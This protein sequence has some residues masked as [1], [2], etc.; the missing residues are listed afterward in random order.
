MAGDLRGVKLVDLMQMNTDAVCQVTTRISDPVV[1]ASKFWE[2]DA[3]DL[4]EVSA[5]L[6]SFFDSGTTPSG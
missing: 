6:V 5:E 4:L 1:P 3:E 2:L